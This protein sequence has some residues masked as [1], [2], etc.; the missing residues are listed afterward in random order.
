MCSRTAADQT[1][2]QKVSFRFMIHSLWNEFLDTLSETY[3][4]SH[5]VARFDESD[6]Q[7]SCRGIVWWSSTY[8]IA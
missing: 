1:D 8:A 4:F 2:P 6:I 3:A 5:E 7:K